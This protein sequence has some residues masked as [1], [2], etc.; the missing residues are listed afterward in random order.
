MKTIGKKYFSFRMVIRRGMSLLEITI[1]IAIFTMAMLIVFM[2]TIQGYRVNRFAIQQAD[3]LEHARRGIETMV[4]EMREASASDIGSYPIAAAGSQSFSFYSNIDLDNNVE[5]IR[6]FLDGTHFM[7]GVIEPSGS[8]LSY[9]AVTETTKIISEY[10]RNGSNPVF[11]YY[12]GDYPSSTVPLATP[13]NPNEIKLVEL[14]LNI[15]IDPSTPPDDIDLNN[16][17]Q[18]RNVK[19]NL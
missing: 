11:I 3:A 18:I 10:A 12:N 13:A 7:K 6:Y 2:Y 17:V 8:P 1:T 5:K 4:R 9:P 14:R 15:N 19:D 16:F